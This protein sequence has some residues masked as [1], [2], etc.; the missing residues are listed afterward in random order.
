MNTHSPLRRSIP[1]EI[2]SHP[3]H[4]MKTNVLDLPNSPE[5]NIPSPAQKAKRHS[6][7]RSSVIAAIIAAAMMTGA[8]HATEFSWTGATGGDWNTGANWGGSAPLAADTAL[9]NTTMASVVNAAAV[10]ITGISF[11]TS[12][13]TGSGTFTLGT[14]GTPAY[15]LG[16]NGTIQVLSTLTGTGKTISINAPIVLTPASTTTAGAYTFSNDSATTTNTLNF[17]GPIS[18]STTSNTETLT[19]SGANTGT[20]TISGIISKGS[21]TTFAVAK[22]GT[23]TWLLSG[24]NTY[25]GGTTISD[26]TLTTTNA[27]G[28]GSGT[29][30]VNANGTLLV[31]NAVTIANAISGSG[32]VKLKTTAAGALGLTGNLSG[33]TGTLDILANGGGGFVYLNN[34]GVPS[35]SATVKVE[36]GGS[37]RVSTGLTYNSSLQLSGLGNAGGLG[38]LR[39]DG[40]NGTTWSGSVTLLSDAGI[41]GTASGT[42]SGVIGD[43]GSNYTLSKMGPAALSITNTNTYGGKTIIRGGTLSFNSGNVSA[44]ANQALGTNAAV[45]LIWTSDTNND[46]TAVTLNYTGA[47]AATLAKNVNALST[48]VSGKGN[49][50]QNSSASGLLTLTGT[51]ANNGTI[52]T[53][54]GGTNGITVSGTIAGASAGS[55]LIVNGGAGL[56]TLAGNNSYK[57][58]TTVSAG[59]LLINGDQSAATGAVSVSSTLGGSGIIGGAV[60]I[61]NGGFIAA[62]NNNTGILTVAALSLNPTSTAQFA[63]NGTGAAGT[64]YDKIVVNSSGALV[65]NGAFTINFGNGSDLANTTNINLF[66]F[67]PGQSSGDFSSLVST[68]HYDGTWTSSGAAGAKTFTLNTG[69]QV[70]AFSEVTGSLTVVPEPTTWALLAFSLTIVIIRRRRTT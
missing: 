24:S 10:G 28:L 33:F 64:D 69:S 41:G 3:Q 12:A 66:S 30:T 42:V 39:I 48:T 67:T 20:N 5:S 23:G 57:G 29:A 44:T 65:L 6:R 63:I 68:G 4:D 1:A 25:N 59:T 22:T 53:L 14:T 47:G 35:S 38:A 40:G 11:D 19:L 34:A 37:L 60:T 46:S 2:S 16:N 58:T 17:G 49:I 51:L 54:S 15:T 26:G 55:N 45:D 70:L 31:D 7:G 9:F 21:A 8:A 27:T 61:E 52:L 32:L 62:G 36:N 13:G 18:A 56:T 50:I 43:G